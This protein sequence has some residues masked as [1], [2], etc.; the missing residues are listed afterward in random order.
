MCLITSP[1]KFEKKG[2]KEKWL[3][4]REVKEGNNTEE[5]KKS[6]TPEE[7]EEEQ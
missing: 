6:R 2:Q 1:G 5:M 4:D 7:E 3:D